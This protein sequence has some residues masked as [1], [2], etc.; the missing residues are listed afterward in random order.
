MARL[1]DLGAGRI[2][3]MDADGIDVALLSITSPGVQVF[4]AV[5]AGVLAREA[6]DALAAACAAHPERFAGLRRGGAAAPR[7]RGR[8]LERAMRTPA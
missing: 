7:E 2:A 5:T 4:D 6:N 8:E 1:V 3:Q